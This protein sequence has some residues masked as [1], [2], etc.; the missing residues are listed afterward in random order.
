MAAIRNCY[1]ILMA[2]DDIQENLLYQLRIA[3]IGDTHWHDG[4]TAYIVKHQVRYLA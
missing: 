4:S 3:A 2:F 1:N